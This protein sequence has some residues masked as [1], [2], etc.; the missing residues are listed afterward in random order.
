MNQA[1][2]K[3]TSKPEVQAKLQAL[4][5]DYDFDSLTWANDRDLI[6]GRV[7][8][9][10][11]WET[12]S[13]LWRQV[14]EGELRSWIERHQGRGLDDR[15]LRFWELILGLSHRQVNAWMSSPGRR[16]W[17]RRNRP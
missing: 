11:D 3:A 7:L 6:I 2:V 1:G 4:F 5:W 8:A 10:G 12:V 13:W 9:Y 15:K 17:E 16:L 14:G